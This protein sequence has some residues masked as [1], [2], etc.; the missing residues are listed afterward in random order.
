[1]KIFVINLKNAEER[2]NFMTQQLKELNLDFEFIDAIYGKDFYDDDKYFAREASKKYEKR[3]MTPGEIGCALSHQIIYKKMIA[4]NIPYALIFED[5]AVISPDLIK[6]LPELEKNIHPNQMINL[7]KCDLAY[8][9][10]RIHIYGEYFL[11]KPY[12]VKYGSI[13]YAVGYIITKEA[14]ETILS[15]NF[16]VFTPADNWGCF[17]KLIDFRGITPTHKL[18]R[19][20][21]SFESS[22]ITGIRDTSKSSTIGT[23]L[24][25]HFY[26]QWALGRFL[27]KI[28]QRT[29]K[30]W[31]KK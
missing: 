31:M 21:M 24:F 15:I 17:R 30:K 5:D 28:Y 26:T 23:M 27:K 29:V 7:A 18:V 25:Y 12:M 6:V 2:R 14:A 1:M 13:A 8:K 11:S 9:K 20:N 3:L 10:N 4:E 22:I 19:Q 16:P